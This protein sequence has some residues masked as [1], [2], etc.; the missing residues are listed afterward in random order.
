[1]APHY[2]DQ[3]PLDFSH[4][5]V[6]ELRNLLYENYFRSG[7]V[8]ALVRTAGMPPAWINWDQPMVLVWDDVLSTLQ[9]QGKLR[10]LLQN[11]IE[12]PDTALAERLR[13]LTADQPVTAAPVHASGDIPMPGSAPGEYEKIIA[14]ES[15]LLDVSFLQRGTELASAVVRLL[16][17]LDGQQFFGTA[18]RI[19]EDLLLTNHHVL[20]AASGRPATAVDVWFGYER[21]LGGQPKAHVSV[22]GRVETITGEPMHDWA[23]IRLAGPAPEG[24]PVIKLSGAAPVAVDDRVYI[25]QHPYGGVKKIG[26]IHN[27]VRYVDNDV[28]RYWTDTDGGSSGS[29]V[30][31]EQW[32][33]VALHHRWVSDVNG[34]ATEIRNQGRRIERVVAGLVGAGIG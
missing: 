17:T 8:I 26:M 27:V 33:V 6:K 4:P 29:P 12:S 16:V 23:V 1:M 14:G 22:P 30:F 24:V 10:R 3:I 11:L 31:N 19:G 25:I 20:F 13:E 34:T 32:Q 28:I 15:T 9:K 21:A 2:L 7:E 18:F 5:A